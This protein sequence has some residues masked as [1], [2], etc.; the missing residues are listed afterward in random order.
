M[1]TICAEQQSGFFFTLHQNAILSTVGYK[2]SYK[3]LENEVLICLHGTVACIVCVHQ[4]RPF[5]TVTACQPR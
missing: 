5:E 1:L 3:K 2:Y 4:I